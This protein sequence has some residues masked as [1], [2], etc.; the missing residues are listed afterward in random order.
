MET[1]KQVTVQ[2]KTSL[3]VSALPI[4]NSVKIGMNG[5]YYASPLSA[6]TGD[7][8]QAA[9]DALPSIESRLEPSTAEFINGAVVTSVLHYYTKQLPEDI[10]RALSNQWVGCLKEFP[11]YVIEEAFLEY[12]KREKK[13]KAPTPG[14]IYEICLC[15]VSK[16]RA[17]KSQCDKIIAE[18]IHEPEPEQ[19]PDEREALKVRITKI[20]DEAKRNMAI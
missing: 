9:R 7:L 15:L 16:V 17:L 6:I 11:E 3:P 5:K 1:K 12:V 4:L 10:R 14:E 19:T 8:K 20:M 2:K 13:R 18:P